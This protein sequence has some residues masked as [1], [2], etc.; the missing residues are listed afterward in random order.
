MEPCRRWGVNVEREELEEDTGGIFP[1][2]WHSV[3]NYMSTL[4][5]SDVQVRSGT[6]CGTSGKRA[7]VYF[8]YLHHWPSAKSGTGCVTSTL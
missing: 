5:S 4:F 7:Y 1:I 3:V 2:I 8:R 6:V